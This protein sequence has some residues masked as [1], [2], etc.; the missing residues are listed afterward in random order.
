MVFTS[1]G[2][3]LD[4]NTVELRNPRFDARIRTM[5]RRRQGD[6]DKYRQRRRG[7]KAMPFCRGEPAVQMGTPDMGYATFSA[8][9]ERR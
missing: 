6:G 7:F 9:N 8:S 4:V 3:P 2:V 1:D 5:G